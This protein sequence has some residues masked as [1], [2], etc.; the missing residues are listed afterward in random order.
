MADEQIAQSAKPPLLSVVMS[1]YNGET[2]LADAV[3]SILA[4]TFRDFEFIIID[5][6]SSDGS[7]GILQ[8]Y[9]ARDPRIRIVEQENTGLTIA[10]CRGVEMSRGTYV[11]RMDADDISLP[12]RFEKQ[13]ALLEMRPD[14]SAS[15]CGVEHFFDDG[16]ISHIAHIAIN[17]QLIPLYMCFSNRIGG[18][19]QVMFRRSAYDAAGGYD[20]SFRYAQDY[21]LWTRLLD[22]GGFGVLDDTLYR[23]RTGH[24]SISKRSKSAQTDNSLRTTRSQYEKVTGQPIDLETAQA[25][26]DFWWKNPA[27]ET[28][29]RH[30]L[31]AA[32]AMSRAVGVFFDR[33]PHLRAEEFEVRRNLAA[34]WWWRRNET[35]PFDLGRKALI[36]AIVFG[37]GLQALLAKA[38]GKSGGHA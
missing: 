6:G 7:L 4:Q 33:H 18:H 9:A 31:G 23:F 3:D 12:N 30:L 2:Y 14:L 36:L 27:S 28:D 13:I 35:E 22:T 34:R 21:D 29:Y 15:T 37:L 25:M 16:S 11:A 24:D 26:R 38:R 19:G 10:L 8:D 20:P 1:V 5:D 17:P 32:K